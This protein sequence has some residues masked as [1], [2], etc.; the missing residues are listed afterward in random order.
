MRCSQWAQEQEEGKE[1][2][3]AAGPHRTEGH[4]YDRGETRGSCSLP[5]L[6][7]PL[8]GSA[9]RSCCGECCGLARRRRERGTDPAVGISRDEPADVAREVGCQS[10]G[11]RVRDEK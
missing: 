11:E 6:P 2:R 5:L 4:H 3:A 8:T 1:K 10:R 7:F 9:T